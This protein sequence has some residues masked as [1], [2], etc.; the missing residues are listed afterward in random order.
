M[1][2]KPEVDEVTGVETTGHSWDGIK[3]LNKPLPKWWVWV[4]NVTIVWAFGYW[5]VYPA[6]PLISSYTTGF[7]ANVDAECTATYLDRNPLGSRLVQVGDDDV[8]TLFG[9]APTD[10]QVFLILGLCLF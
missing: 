9:Q 8:N 7:F 4:L 1:A 6:W 3:E 2:S 5:L 10:R